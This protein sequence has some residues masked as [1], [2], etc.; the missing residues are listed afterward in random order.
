VPVIARA[1]DLEASARL[2]EAGAT[3]AHPDA[4]EASLHLGALALEV[5]QVPADQ[6]GASVAEV[7]AT[8][9]RAL[10]EDRPVR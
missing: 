9:Y 2:R 1:R 10:E 3:F 5:L 8:D 7:R 6:I 4:I